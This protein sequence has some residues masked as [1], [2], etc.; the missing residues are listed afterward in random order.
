MKF[1][2]RTGLA[3]LR[4]IQLNDIDEKLRS[5]IINEIAT[6]LDDE[7][8]EY[9]L[10]RLGCRTVSQENVATEALFGTKANIERL[11]KQM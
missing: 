2:E 11:L 10:D 5:R 9:I 3:P 8:A 4:E 6:L 1:S 7:Q